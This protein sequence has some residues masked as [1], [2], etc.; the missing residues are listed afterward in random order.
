MLFD[1]HAE[2]REVSDE[3]DVKYWLKE[4]LSNANIV[5][6]SMIVEAATE[7]GFQFWF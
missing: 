7:S 5:N 3:K 1:V 2:E 4:L 6:V